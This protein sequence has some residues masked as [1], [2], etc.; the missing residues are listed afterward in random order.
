MAETRKYQPSTNAVGDAIRAALGEGVRPVQ[1]GDP[2][3]PPAHRRPP[4]TPAAPTTTVRTFTFG[5]TTKKP[6]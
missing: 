1:P 3:P 6:Q 2:H 4:T 5:A